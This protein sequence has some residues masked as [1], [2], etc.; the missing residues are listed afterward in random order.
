MRRKIA[1]GAGLPYDPP[2]FPAPPLNQGNV[3]PQ[4]DTYPKNPG[5]YFSYVFSPGQIQGANPMPSRWYPDCVLMLQSDLQYNCVEI[6]AAYKPSTVL[7]SRGWVVPD[8]VA[9][10]LD[11]GSYVDT[12]WPA[13][14]VSLPNRQAWYGFNDLQV[15]INVPDLGTVPGGI[16]PQFWTNPSKL[17]LATVVGD[18]ANSASVPSGLVF[19]IYGAAYFTRLVLAHWQDFSD[20]HTTLGT[21][22]EPVYTVRMWFDQREK[23]L[24]SI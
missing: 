7:P 13:D 15:K 16:S 23:S 5:D 9:L 22:V 20:P 1:F 21:A 3:L 10:S 12:I 4:P 24:R 18:P 2:P 17:A 14:K 19:R 11:S 8:T 6:S